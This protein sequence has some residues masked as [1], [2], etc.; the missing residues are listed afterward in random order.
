M[1]ETESILYDTSMVISFFDGMIF[2][3]KILAFGLDKI[4]AFGLDK[5]LYLFSPC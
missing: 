3:D 2:S 5:I 1:T 4:L